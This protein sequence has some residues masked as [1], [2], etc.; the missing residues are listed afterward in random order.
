MASDTF[1]DTARGMLAMAGSS[2][3][4]G[5]TT[6]I[7]KVLGVGE[8]GVSGLHPF[9]VSAGRFA[10]ALLALLV[11][12]AL[13]PAARPDFAGARWRWHIGRS[14][15]GWL[16]ITSMFAAAARM[17]L[18]EATAISFLSPLVTMTLAILLLKESSEIRKWAGAT[19][20]MGGALILLQPGTEAFRPAAFLALAAAAFM[21]T[22]AI[23]IKRLS[24][25]EPPLRILLINNAIGAT[26]SAI[27]AA[28]VWTA[29][30]ASQWGLLVVLGTVMVSA[31]A[32]FI[33]A[34]RLGDASLVIPVFYMVL[35]F[36]AVYD[37][38]LFGVGLSLTALIGAALIVAGAV[39][40]ALTTP[41]AA[42][43]RRI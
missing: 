25:S 40:I 6:L 3:L 21:G 1:R 31:Q 9:Q 15:C 20:S 13:R 42:H 32:L 43:R 34:M 4:V 30:A 36:A 11:V 5:A 8:P 26:V 17:P 35:V 10:F 16:G 39:F 22:E 28:T 2:A 27:A 19:L 37:F 23:F 33:H 12:I 38:L 18:A 7:A 41:S 14:L 24:G 29:P